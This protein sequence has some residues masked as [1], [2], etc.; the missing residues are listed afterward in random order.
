MGSQIMVGRRTHRCI[1][2]KKSFACKECRSGNQNH[3]DF[4][5]CTVKCKEDFYRKYMKSISPYMAKKTF[6]IQRL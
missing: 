6:G 2:C 4:F 5:W 3:E 1:M